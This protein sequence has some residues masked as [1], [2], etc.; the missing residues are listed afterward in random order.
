MLPFLLFLYFF[1]DMKFPFY[2]FVMYFPFR[3]LFPPKQWD[4]IR[5]A[6]CSDETPYVNSF[7]ILFDDGADIPKP[8][9]KNLFSVAPHG[10]LT[11][12]W[13]N[14][15]GSKC[16]FN[17]GTK[18]LVAPML[19]SLPWMGDI[20][21]WTCCFPA[22]SESMKKIMRSGSNIGMIPGGFQ[23]ATLYQ[24]GKYRV[25]L[26]SRKGFI[27][28]ALEYGYS[29]QPSFVF[30]EELT[31]W[32]IDLIPQNIAFFLNKF[33]IPT[34]IFIGKFF[35]MPDNDIDLVVVVGKKIPLPQISKPSA[36]D[37]D[38]YHGLFLEAYQELFDKYKLTC[39]VQGAK[40][41]LEIL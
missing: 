36:A 7:E 13:S 29:L 24:R 9:E 16:F 5:N 18:W 28:Y 27:K 19:C 12:G 17:S 6:L 4:W 3:A 2:F 15:V 40:A 11:L 23:E 26:K 39:S 38:K 8:N 33:N 34:C 32:T 22:D 25:F 31:Y 1:W 20:M 14:I 41:V 37:V 10:I 35:F 30:G 21:R